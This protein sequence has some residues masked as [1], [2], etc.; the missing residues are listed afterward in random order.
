MVCIHVRVTTG[1]HELARSQAAHLQAVTAASASAA[2]AAATKDRAATVNCLR[3]CSP[4]AQGHGLWQA[5]KRTELRPACATHHVGS[6]NHNRVVVK[7]GC[8][9]TLGWSSCAACHQ[10]TVM[11]RRRLCPSVSP[12]S[13]FHL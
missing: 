5:A 7:P 11:Q 2:A 12:L 3:W 9:Y 8:T 1:V 10:H 13:V 4:G 6:R